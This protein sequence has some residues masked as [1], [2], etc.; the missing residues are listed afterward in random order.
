[1]KTLGKI[2][3][4]IGHAAAPGPDIFTGPCGGWGMKTHYG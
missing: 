4:L 2:D 1:M 3:S